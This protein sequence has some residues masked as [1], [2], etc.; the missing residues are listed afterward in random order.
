MSQALESRVVAVAELTPAEIAALYHLFDELFVASPEVFERDLKAKDRVILLHD[1]ES[2]T[3]QGFSTLALYE[4]EAQGR[5]VSVV[6]SGDTVVRPAA[7]GTPELPRAWIHTVLAL[8]AGACQPLYW[9]LLTSGYRTYRFL[10]VFFREFYP[11]HD[12]PTPPEEQALLDELAR[13]RFGADFDRERGIVRFA[14]GAT[15][16]RPGAAD[17][18]PGRLHDPHVAFFLRQNSGHAEGDELAC[19]TRI[20]PD[21]F[22]A[23]GRRMA[24][25]AR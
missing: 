17:P 9:L 8:A 24:Q 6:Y 5:R 14:G 21:N 10:T 12:H 4:T 19:L 16:L 7:W 3:L 23:A 22:T 18:N 20:H 1:P 25:L 13:Q 11:R 15:P 2:H